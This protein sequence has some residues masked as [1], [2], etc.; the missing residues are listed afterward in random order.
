M[1]LANDG[2]CLKHHAIEFIVSWVESFV[3]S[4]C[5][6]LSIVGSGLR[7]VGGELGVM[8]DVLSA[9]LI[10]SAQLSGVADS[11]QMKMC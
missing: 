2:T 11:D 3:V 8:G 7:I 1:M 6:E 10:Q 9:M 4:M 5:D